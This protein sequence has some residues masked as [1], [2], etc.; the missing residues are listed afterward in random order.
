MFALK[1]FSIIAEKLKVK[2]ESKKLE[3]IK[4]LGFLSIFNDNMVSTSILMLVFFG[5]ILLILGK[6]YLIDNGFMKEGQS[7]FFIY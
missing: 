2:G 7:F 6:D 3:D 5:I 1:I 4:F